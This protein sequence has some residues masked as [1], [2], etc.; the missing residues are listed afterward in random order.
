MNLRPILAAGALWLAGCAGE[1]PDQPPTVYLGESVCAHCNMI[2]SDE[3]FACATVVRG[4]RGPEAHLFDDFNCQRDFERSHPDAEIIARWAHD[5]ETGAWFHPEEGWFVRSED[6]VTP[7]G[8]Q[9]VLFKDE[10]AAREY[11]ARMGAVVVT[12]R[13]AHDPG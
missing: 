6:L 11:A 5:Y 3:R 7:M 4:P 12:F 10:Q 8:S 1:S 2:I 9:M 13:D